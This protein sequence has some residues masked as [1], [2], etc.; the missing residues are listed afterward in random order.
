VTRPESRLTV[1]DEVWQSVHDYFYDPTLR[2]LDWAAMRDKYRPLVAAAADEEHAAVINRMLDELAASHTRYYTPDDP[3]Y[4]QL[5]DIFAGP[6]RRALRRVF[7]DGQVM[8]PSLGIFTQRIEDKTFIH[9]VLDGFPAAKAGLRV[10]D[11]LLAADGTPYHPIKS[12]TAKVNQEVT[13]QVRRSR[14]ETPHDVVVVPQ[15]VKPNEAFL[16]AMRESARVI[17]THGVAIGYIHVWSYA[18]RQYQQLLEDEISSGT[19]KEAEALILDLR[20]GWGGAQA[21]YLDIFNAQGPTVTMVDRHGDVSFTNVKWRKPVVMLVNG[22][23]RSG[24]EILAYGFKKYGLGE[25]IGTRTAGAVLAAR[26]FL[27]SDG[28]LLILAV[29]DV[30][31]DGQ[32]LE[33]VGVTPTIEVPFPVEY[34]QGKDPQLERALELLSRS[35][36]G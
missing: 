21:H 7:P 6:L 10:G 15:Q 27:L 30:L 8:Y 23:T 4:Y 32:R 22:G 28:S 16:K 24:K 5:L 25:V 9:G 35:V 1:F 3:A 29:N 31:V 17:H 20:D 13:L 34:A 18:G 12:L 33:G 26:A 14:D 11:E 19:L 2:Q 36:R